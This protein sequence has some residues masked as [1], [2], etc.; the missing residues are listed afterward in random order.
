[1]W[2]IVVVNERK[3]RLAQFASV[4]FVENHEVKE[5]FLYLIF[6][7]SQ[8]QRRQVKTLPVPSKYAVQPSKLLNLMPTTESLGTVMKDSTFLAAINMMYLAFLE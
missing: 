1:M 2:I 3:M 8:A 4:Y 5:T 7:I 6:S